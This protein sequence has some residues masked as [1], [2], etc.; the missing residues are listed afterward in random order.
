MKPR[1]AG[2]MHLQ[3]ANIFSLPYLNNKQDSYY[4]SWE[5]SSKCAYLTRNK[6]FTTHNKKLCQLEIHP[7]LCAHCIRKQ[8]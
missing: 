1:H 8:L 3:I 7:P 2:A 6:H 4:L 5:A